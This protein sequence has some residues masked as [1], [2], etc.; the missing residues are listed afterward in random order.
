MK[1]LKKFKHTI[2]NLILGLIFVTTML[3]ISPPSDDFGYYATVID[4]LQ[5]SVMLLIIYLAAGLFFDL[6]IF[7]LMKKKL[8]SLSIY[9]SIVFFTLSIFLTVQTIWALIMLSKW[10]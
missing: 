7:V 10:N 6:I 8:R 3:K 5:T 4:I 2:I 1:I 9:L